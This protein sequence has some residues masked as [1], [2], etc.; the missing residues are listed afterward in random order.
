MSQRYADIVIDLSHEAVDRPF[1][2]RIPDELSSRAGIGSAVYVPFGNGNKKRLGYIIDITDKPKWDPAKTKSIL[3]IPDSHLA[4]ETRMIRLAFWM[5]EHYGSTMIAALKTVMPVKERVGKKKTEIDLSD[6]EPDFSA[7]DNL[8]EE[9]QR[10]LDDFSKDFREGRRE[11]YLLKGITGSGKTEVY[12]RMAEYV[13]SQG[14]D[15]IV[16]VPEIALTYQTIARFKTRFGEQISILNS[17]LSKGEKYREFEKAKSGQTRIMIG[18]RSALFA[19]FQNLGLIIIDE[20]HDNAYKSEKTP[21]YHARETAIQRAS[22]EG[23]SVVLGSATPSLESFYKAQQGLYKLYK[24]EKR[25]TGSSLA[26]VIVADMRDELHKGNTSIFSHPLYNA[27]KEAFEAGNQVMLFLNRRGYNTSVFC[28][29]CGKA[30]QCPHCDVS[31]SLH[32][33]GKLMCHY[34]GFSQPMPNECPHCHSKMI[35][36]A[37]VGTQ[38]VERQVKKF[39]PEARTLRMD[40]D[41]TR[42][43]DDHGKIIE[44]FRKHEAD[45]LIGTQ[46]IVKGHDFPNVTVV[47][48]ILADLG[49]FDSDFQSG[50]RTFDLLTQAVGRAG[51]ASKAGTAVIQTYQP[52]HYAIE[53]A[54]RQDY[55]AFYQQ[56]ISYRKLLHYPP[57][58]HM[59]CVQIQAKAEEVAI[60]LSV[61]IAGYLKREFET[62]D[63]IGPSDALIYRMND[64]YRRVIY[65]KSSEYADLSRAAEL[66]LNGCRIIDIG[67]INAEV[68]FDFNPLH[69]S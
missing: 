21:K 20:E 64:I 42:N 50:E 8:N 35:D 17:R 49:L 40:K 56:E 59:L 68:S 23:A 22:M 54:A 61:R 43:K 9:Q 24:L 57:V 48:A 65:M 15:V 34:C 33:D 16:L 58:D 4:V 47:G 13:I 10:I 32:K 63:I 11:T 55:D 66:V 52:D 45:C 46:M 26:N 30:I 18:P 38:L 14:K 44:A 67:K 27:M 12:I 41:T 7:I 69:L 31:L 5:K 51:R 28:R 19:P 62:C 2:Y 39:F 6:F 29:D 36:G 60:D 53:T 25:A 1:S 37:G 3:E